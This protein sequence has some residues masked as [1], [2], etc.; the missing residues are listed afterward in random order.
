MP[1]ILPENLLQPLEELSDTLAGF[2]LVDVEEAADGFL[3][4]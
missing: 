1:D 2:F 4:A 3:R